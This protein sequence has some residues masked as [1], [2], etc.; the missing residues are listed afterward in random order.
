MYKHGISFMILAEE[1]QNTVLFDVNQFKNMIKGNIVFI[2][3]GSK[4][5]F[6]HSLFN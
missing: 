5:N 4:E 6:Y 2:R 1:D 3:S